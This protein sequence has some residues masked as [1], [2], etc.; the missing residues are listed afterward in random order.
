MA[1]LKLE[2]FVQL[3]R[4]IISWN[5]TSH[6]LILGLLLKISKMAQLKL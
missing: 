2:N 4:W 1:Q 6:N 5:S 3:K